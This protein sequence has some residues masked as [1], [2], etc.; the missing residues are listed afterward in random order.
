MPEYIAK[1]I[2]YWLYKKKVFSISEMTN[3]SLLHRK[4]LSK[5][6]YIGRK[7]YSNREES[8]DGTI[9]YLFLVKKKYFIESVYI[10]HKKRKTLC[11]SSQI[12][13][14]MRCIFCM[15][16]KQGF[17]GQLKTRDIINQILSIPE[18]NSLTNI[19]F[20]GMGEPLDNIRVLFKVL[21][22][23][24]SD[25]GLAWSPKRI[26]VSTVGIIPE[27]KHFLKK[28]KVHLAVSIHSPFHI[29]RISLSPV[30]KKHPITE[31][32]NII[33]KYNFYNQRKIS[34]EYIIFSGLNDSIKHAFALYKL[35]KN[36]HCRV[37]LLKYNSLLNTSLP[38][39]N[40]AKMIAFCKYLNS[41]K[42]IC[43][44]RSSRGADISAACGMLCTKHYY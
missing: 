10:P 25:Y 19:V 30:E 8:S 14:R 11:I 35:L 6:F 39:S 28:S 17:K 36:I 20:M 44:I 4:Q 34:F 1:Q 5:Y 18:T 7:I 22:I 12:G 43:T 32:I 29:E 15:T 9:K 37:N 26:T 13:C 33:Q 2:T 38:S 27:L 31:I 21:E 42:I 24:T 23:L 16:G 3:I 41:K 40:L